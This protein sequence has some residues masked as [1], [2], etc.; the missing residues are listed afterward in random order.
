MFPVSKAI[1]NEFEQ[2]HRI[3]WIHILEFLRY[4]DARKINIHFLLCSMLDVSA[5]I[6]EST[7]STFL[8]WNVIFIFAA[9]ISKEECTCNF[10][11]ARNN[12]MKSLK[13]NADLFFLMSSFRIP[14]FLMIFEII[15][16]SS[17]LN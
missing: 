10:K 2:C 14:L 7:T 3:C 15:F 1:K 12:I 11:W 9:A 4:F 13:C 16:Y 6:Y 17:F 5:N 8:V